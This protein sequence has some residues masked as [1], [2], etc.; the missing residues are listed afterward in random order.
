MIR[1]P[2]VAGTFYPSSPHELIEMIDAFLSSTPDYPRRDYIGAVVPHAGY[3]YSGPIAAHAYKALSTIR[4][5]K[6][7]V[8]GP[9][10]TG[11]G[12]AVSVWPDGA[13]E[14][15]LGT[16]TVDSELARQIVDRSSFAVPD[17]DAHIFEHSVE[18]QLPFLQRIY[19][20]FAFVPITMMYQAPDAAEDLA[21]SLPEDVLFLASSDFSHYVP[22]DVG[23]AK[24]LEAIRYILNLDVRGFYDYVVSND[25]SACGIGPIMTLMAYARRLGA[26]AELLA[27]GNS[28]DVTGDYDSVVDYAAIVFYR[29]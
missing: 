20:D 8:A 23:R 19:G 18:V 27:F 5:S 26:R 12:A 24:D 16:V 1:R 15:P 28:G 29:K 7:V 21:A 22:A 6:I 2:A 25:V 3:I 14:T 13:W 9:N 11:Y 4:P 10:H 17:Y